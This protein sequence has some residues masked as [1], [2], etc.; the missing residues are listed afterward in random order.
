MP[1]QF[2]QFAV[3]DD[4][5]A[6]K[7]GTDGVLLGAWANVT[8]AK[9]ILDVGTGSGL[10][11]LMLAQRTSAETRID[12]IE[13]EQEDA[14]QA[15]ENV[16]GSPWANRINVINASLQEYKSPQPYDLIVSNPP[17]FDSLLP[18]GK[19]KSA[20]HAQTLSQAVLL[21][22]SSEM[23]SE[24][25]TLAVILPTVEGNSFHA[26][27]NLHGFFCSV[28]CAVFPTTQKPQERWLFQ[29]FKGITS[30]KNEQLVLQDKGQWTES[31]Q[32]L[33]RGFYL[34]F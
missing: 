17:F 8:S 33:T 20:R 3:A 14:Q 7:V 24:K 9:T 34:K 4:R 30:C 15:Q 32:T 18:A 2:K 21:K 11:A 29:F 10:I 27:A 6:M 12:A 23:L 1:F 19:R 16:N 5:C 25:G 13:I 31:Y 22:F 26:L 28:Q